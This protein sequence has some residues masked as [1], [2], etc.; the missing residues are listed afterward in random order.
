MGTMPFREELSREARDF[1]HERTSRVQ[2]V[3]LMDGFPVHLMRCGRVSIRTG[4][5]RGKSCTFRIRKRQKTRSV[6][7]CGSFCL[8]IWCSGLFSFFRM[9]RKCCRIIPMCCVRFRGRFLSL[10]FF[11]LFF[12][13]CFSGQGAHDHGHCIQ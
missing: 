1:S 4:Y 7:S 11:F 3:I 6:D 12:F 9:L 10:L 2:Y 13:L 8:W 5:N